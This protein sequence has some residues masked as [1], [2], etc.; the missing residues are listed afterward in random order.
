M[1]WN[2]GAVQLFQ[3][4]SF[5]TYIKLCFSNWKSESDS[6]MNFAVIPRQME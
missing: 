2:K 3:Y 1:F 4:A 6:G 5:I